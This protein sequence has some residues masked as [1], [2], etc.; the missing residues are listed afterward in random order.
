M[1]QH[2]NRRGAAAVEK[3]VV[4]LGVTVLLVG[5]YALFGNFLGQKFAMVVEL[6]GGP[7]ANSLAVREAKQTGGNV[8][9]IILFVVGSIGFSV[10][11]LGP[12][13]L[14][15]LRLRRQATLNAL[16]DQVGIL[17]PLADRS[18]EFEI[19]MQEL[20]S[21][22]TEVKKGGI[23]KRVITTNTRA[24]ASPADETISHAIVD[25]PSIDNI[26][27]DQTVGPGIDLPPLVTG[28]DDSATITRVR[29]ESGIVQLPSRHDDTPTLNDDSSILSSV[30]LSELREQAD[31]DPD[32]VSKTIVRKKLPKPK[33]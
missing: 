12:L 24:I 2:M 23:G 9:W 29:P 15:K 33:Y 5:A 22:A 1:E 14:P 10:F 25:R 16:A 27:P 21:L 13:L 4:I 3:L 28:S 20:R 31:A 17:E 6:L 19:Q 7:P 11:V 18:Q 26:D 8:L 30:P 32:S